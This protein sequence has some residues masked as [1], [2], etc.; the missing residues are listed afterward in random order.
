[1][2]RNKRGQATFSMKASEGKDN[3]KLFESL[4]DYY[5]EKDLA[6]EKER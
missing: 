5:Q 6:R 1:M 4:I 2:V 3:N